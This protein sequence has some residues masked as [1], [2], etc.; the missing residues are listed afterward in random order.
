MTIES[1]ALWHKR[2]RPNPTVEDFNVQFGCHLEEIAE[3]LIC[4]EGMSPQSTN[5]LRT[6]AFMVS[7]AAEGFKTGV[8]SAWIVNRIEFLDGIC[9]QLV[10]GVGAAHCAHMDVVGGTEEVMRSNWSKCVDGEFI[11][12]ANGKIKKPESYSPPELERFV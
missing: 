9:D 1:I 3:M 7:G 2:A 10:T 11:R 8:Y 5:K 4:L 12:D 6:L